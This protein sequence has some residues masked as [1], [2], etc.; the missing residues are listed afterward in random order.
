[1]PPVK[2]YFLEISQPISYTSLLPATRCGDCFAGVIL[3]VLAAG[4]LSGCCFERVTLRE[5]M[6]GVARCFQK[7]EYLFSR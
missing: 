2:I 3:L 1:M 6:A 4:L 7:M 5:L